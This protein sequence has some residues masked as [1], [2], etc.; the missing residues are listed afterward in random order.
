MHIRYN[1]GF[2]NCALSPGINMVKLMLQNK[3]AV[4]PTHDCL[5]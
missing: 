4:I 5:I 3:F 1:G 2:V